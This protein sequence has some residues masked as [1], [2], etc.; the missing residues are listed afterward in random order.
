MN[1][2]K[3]LTACLNLCEEDED[4]ILFLSLDFDGEIKNTVN[5]YLE[6]VSEEAKKGM[7]FYYIEQA[8]ESSLAEKNA[9]Q[10]TYQ[11]LLLLLNKASMSD[12]VE[13]TAKYE[14]SLSW[15]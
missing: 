7:R 10:Q 4:A 12:F 2:L 15:F 8:N 6:I 13:L 14:K 5:N 3:Q 1:N 11:Q 9:E